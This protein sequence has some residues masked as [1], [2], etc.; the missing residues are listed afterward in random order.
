VL[1]LLLVAYLNQLLEELTLPCTLQLWL[2][3]I[4]I[5]CIRISAQQ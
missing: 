4:T 2:Q 3:C 1:L 5:F